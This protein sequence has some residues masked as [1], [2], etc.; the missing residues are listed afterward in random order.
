MSGRSE[1]IVCV[2]ITAEGLLHLRWGRVD[3]VAVA[4]VS[5][6]GL[7]ERPSISATLT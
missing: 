3:R 6:D 4:T 2:P 5:Q 7:I 1:I